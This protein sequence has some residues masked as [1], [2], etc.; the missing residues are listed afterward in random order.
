MNVQGN[1]SDQG[2]SNSTTGG[3]V[4]L[5]TD[6]VAQVPAET[7]RE[8]GISI[9]PLIVQIDGKPYRDGMDLDLTQLYNRMRNEKVVPTT[10]APSPGEFE[11]AMRNSLRNGAK[12]VLCITLSSR[13]SSSYQNASLAA[14]L[15]R[16]EDPRRTIVVMDSLSAAACEGFIAITAARAATQ[17]EPMEAILQAARE[18]GR[19]TGLAASFETLEY[20]A[21]G[22]RIGKVAYMMGSLIRIKPIITLD[23]EGTVA[24]VGAAR[25]TN[26]ALQAMVDFVARRVKGRQNL[27]I[28]ILEAEAPEQAARLHELA[29]RQLQP[30]AIHDSVFTPVMGVHTGP[31]LIGLVY[32]YD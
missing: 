17:G 30:A 8:L 27:Q 28:T 2:R 5:I 31:G 4:A 6:S 18:A 16:E 25:N 26:R 32:F 20:L 23:K 21:R 22:G 9:I 29:S 7:A 24:P 1:F 19:R 12:A 11:E 15:L 13:L 14:R 10:I 3:A